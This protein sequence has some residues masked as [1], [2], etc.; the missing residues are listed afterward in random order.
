MKYKI[1]LLAE[2]TTYRHNA[3]AQHGQSVLIESNDYKVLFDVGEIDNAVTYNLE[4]LGIDLSLINDIV[5]SHRHIDHVGA[6]PTM[7]ALLSNQRILLP[8][9]M[10][11]SHIKEHPSKYNFLKPNPDGGYDLALS[12]DHVKQINT[13]KHLLVVDKNG[14]ELRDNIFTTGCEG[15]WMQEQAIVIDQ[16]EYG[17]TLILGCSHPTVEVLLDKARQVTGN[18]KVRGIIGGM[19]YTDYSDAEIESRIDFLE[20]LNLDFIIPS[21]CTTVRGNLHLKNRLGDKVIL[22][23]TYSFGVENSITI[24]D[25]IELDFVG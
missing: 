20:S 6:L 16:K 10:G 22:S 15:D 3:L 2:N 18:N 23:E 5:I 8:L 21:H 7:L 11:E 4:K 24:S 9:Q 25:T 12:H 17:I 13:Y 19:H 14:F 1:T